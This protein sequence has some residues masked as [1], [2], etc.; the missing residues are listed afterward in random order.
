VH[1]HNF[2]SLIQIF[3][4]SVH[5][6]WN[7]TQLK[8]SHTSTAKTL[9]LN[10]SLPLLEH[11]SSTNVLGSDIDLNSPA[12]EI[13]TQDQKQCRAS[14]MSVRWRLY[15]VKGRG[16]GHCYLA[17]RKYETEH[18][19]S[20]LSDYHTEGEGPRSRCYGR[21]AASRLI[22]QPCDG[23]R[24]VFFTFPCNGAPVEWS[25]QAK[26]EVLGEKPVPVPLCPTQIPHGLTRDRTRASTVGDRQLTAWAITLLY[27]ALVGC[28]FPSARLTYKTPCPSATLSTTNPKWTDPGSN[29][30]L[31]GGRPATN[32]LRHGTADTDITLSARCRLA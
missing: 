2:H 13:N 19:P 11:F 3:S 32:R 17:Q 22:V 5:H 30:G 15:Y 12:T 23:R 6:Y 9:E 16:A 10:G 8:V 1:V 7:S 20:K 26:T 27:L 14:Q 25:L 4:N 28:H 24:L 21:T 31:R 18:N 29:P